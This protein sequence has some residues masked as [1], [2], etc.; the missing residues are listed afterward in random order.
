MHFAL[1]REL[2]G[3]G[4]RQVMVEGLNGPIN[5]DDCMKVK[6]SVL[7]VFDFCEDV[8]L[9]K[10][11]VNIVSWQSRKKSERIVSAACG[12]AEPKAD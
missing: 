4:V 11:N 3:F 5:G 1:Q 8:C 2:A 9:R 12:E 7:Q 10:C 6:I